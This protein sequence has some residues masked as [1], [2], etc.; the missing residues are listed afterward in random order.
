MLQKRSIVQFNLNAKVRLMHAGV[1]VKASAKR[2]RVGFALKKY[3][4]FITGS[5]SYPE[6]FHEFLHQQKQAHFADKREGQ[7]LFPQ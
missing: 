2:R 3:K 5:Y 1:E 6:S 7:W 4:V